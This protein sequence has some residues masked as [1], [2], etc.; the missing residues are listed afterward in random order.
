MCFLGLIVGKRTDNINTMLSTRATISNSRLLPG[1]LSTSMRKNQ[2]QQQSVVSSGATASVTLATD[3]TTTIADTTSVVPDMGRHT[4]SDTACSN[5]A[6]SAS[7]NSHSPRSLGR[8]F[9]Y[10]MRRSVFRSNAMER[11]Q[12]DEKEPSCCGGRIRDG[13]HR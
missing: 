2:V 11:E 12:L 1:F 6:A 5:S 7:A 8:A 9:R 4:V 3:D 13:S 10:L